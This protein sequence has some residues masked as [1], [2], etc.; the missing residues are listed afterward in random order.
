MHHFSFKFKS[1]LHPLS[2]NLIKTDNSAGHKWPVIIM[3]EWSKGMKLNSN[4]NIVLSERILIEL[5]HDDNLTWKNVLEIWD[6]V[7]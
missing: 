2:G 5:E 6:N 4:P 7:C 1:A 3:I